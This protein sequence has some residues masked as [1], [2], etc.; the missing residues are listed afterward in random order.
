MRG[1]DGVALR[2]S[3]LL[4]T[5]ARDRGLV[6]LGSSVCGWLFYDNLRGSSEKAEAVSVSAIGISRNK[7]N[8]KLSPSHPYT[9]IS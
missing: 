9:M 5:P 3:A 4:V 6:T 1:S 8:N 7:L 2:D